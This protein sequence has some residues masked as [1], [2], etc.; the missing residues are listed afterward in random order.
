MTDLA[1]AVREWAAARQA[2]TDAPMADVRKDASFG[3]KL[4][5]LADAEAELARLAR[6][7]P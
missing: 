5:R 3:D 6:E 4:R 2:T 7:M 1:T